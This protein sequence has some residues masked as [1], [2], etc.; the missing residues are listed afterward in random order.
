MR[1]LVLQLVTTAIKE[2][3]KYAIPI[4]SLYCS[5]WNIDHKVVYYDQI[6]DMHPSWYKV[7]LSNVSI[8]EDHYDYIMCLDADA[9]FQNNEIDLRHVISQIIE[10]D[11]YIYVCD[12]TANG[13]LINC[14]VVIYQCHYN[15]TSFIKRWIREGQNDLFT[16][17]WEQKTLRR[18]IEDES[19]DTS[20]VKILPMNTFNS[21]WQVIPKDN[22][23]AHYMG[24][25]NETRLPIFQR[26]FRKHFNIKKNF[27][28]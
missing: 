16:F 20:I 5:K 23:I 9:I 26:L 10:P 13:G 14:G 11:K 28:E 3:A 8:N 7:F 18:M 1:I 19:I 12:D 15:T 27:R 6:T 24:R 21:H 2:Y 17:P 25:S 4:N 22:L